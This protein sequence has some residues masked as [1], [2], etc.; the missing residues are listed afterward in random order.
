MRKIGL[1]LAAA[2]GLAAGGLGSGAAS[3][4]MLGVSVVVPVAATTVDVATNVFYRC[5]RIRTCDPRGCWVQRTCL[6]NCPDG[7]SCHPLYGAYGP[8]GGV[9][10]WGAYTFTG[11]GPGGPPWR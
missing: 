1:L 3:A 8:Y 2:I 9:G 5:Q 10:Y 6:R 11:W 4:G 7:I